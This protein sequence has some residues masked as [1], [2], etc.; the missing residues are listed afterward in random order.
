SRPIPGTGDRYNYDD[1]YIH[2]DVSGD[3]GGQTW[4]W[5]YDNSASQ[6]DTDNNNILLSR[7][8]STSLG[9]SK[10]GDDVGLGAELLYTR[11]LGNVGSFHYGFEAGINFLNY[12]V[13]DS[14]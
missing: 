10:T 5:G 14:R 1:G 2:T 8:T 13:S 6:V 9:S 11:L 4:Y 7:T 12:S 3:F